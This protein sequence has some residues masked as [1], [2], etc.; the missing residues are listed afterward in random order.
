MLVATRTTPFFAVVSI[1]FVMGCLRIYT[2]TV[3]V[4]AEKV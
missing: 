4:P 1:I 3:I 2:F